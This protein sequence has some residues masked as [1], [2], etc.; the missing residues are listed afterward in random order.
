MA[1]VKFAAVRGMNDLLPAQAPVWEW[2]EAR[3]MDWLRSYGYRQ[4]RTPVLEHTDLFVRGIGEVTDIVEREMYSFED[5]ANQER[6]TLRPEF[7]AGTVRAAI[8]HSLTYDGPK[9][10]WSMGPL[11]RHERP[12]RGRFRQFHQ[13]NVE[14]LG[15]AG[16][17]IDAELIVML[18]RLW[19][20]LGIASARLEINC[21]GQ[22][23]ERAQHRADLVTY[24]KQ[25]QDELDADSVRRLGTNPLRIL[26]SKNPAM[27]MLLS[28]APQITAYLGDTSL[29][30]FEALQALL[31]AAGIKFKVNPRLVRGLDYYNLTVFEW[32]TDEL[33]SQGTLCGGGRY[34]TLLELLGGK[35]TPAI[36]FAIGIE[37]VIECLTQSG[38]ID[39]SPYADVYVVHQGGETAARAFLTAEQL[40][41]AGLDVICHAGEA[42]L[43]S[44]MKRA[45]ASG[46]E[47]AVIIGETELASDSASVKNLRAPLGEVRAEQRIVPL[48]LLADTLVIELSAA[49]QDH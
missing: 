30:H 8:E 14:A 13:V 24:F 26:D 21:L 27:A 15:F 2:F 38:Q 11:F 31:A 48:H 49:E 25:H 28:D 23:E 22:A 5:R 41:D 10:V 12:Q 47:F 3:V 20:I 29:Q 7:T 32:I 34:D 17:D 45:D 4:I 43:K 40:R 19:K 42:S 6:L 16:P 44:Q 36:G 37:R 39:T 18:A 35:P 1:N 46:A 9:R 33:G